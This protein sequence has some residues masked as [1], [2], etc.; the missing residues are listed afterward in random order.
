MPRADKGKELDL[1]TTAHDLATETLTAV[2]DSVARTAEEL[3]ATQEIQVNTMNEFGLGKQMDLIRPIAFPQ[4]TTK[5]QAFR[6]AA[7]LVFMAETLPDETM[8]HTFLEIAEAIKN[9]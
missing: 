5:Q 9:T 3:E 1:A 4:F 6:F 8:D 7:W 2:G